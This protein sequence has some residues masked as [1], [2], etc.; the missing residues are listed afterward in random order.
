MDASSDGKLASGEIRYAM[1]FGLP[2]VRY[3]RTVQREN[4]ARIRQVESLS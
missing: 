3:A 1:L 4:S 2:T